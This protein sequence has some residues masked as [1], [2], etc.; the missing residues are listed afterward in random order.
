MQGLPENTAE[1]V[2]SGWWLNDPTYG[3]ETTYSEGNSVSVTDAI[4]RADDQVIK[5]Y[6]QSS[7]P[8]A[9][10]TV[11]YEFLDKDGNKIPN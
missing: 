3:S 1:A 10:Y 8:T 11:N 7:I 2:Y 6:A 9:N 4:I 5:F